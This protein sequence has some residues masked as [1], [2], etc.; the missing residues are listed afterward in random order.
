M[1]Q[2][3]QL[4]SKGSS[5]GFGFR[6][7]V[8]TVT[9]TKLQTVMKNLAT[10]KALWPQYVQ[11]LEIVLSVNGVK[12]TLPKG[13]AVNP[14]LPVVA[15][16]LRI[17]KWYDSKN[18][19]FAFWVRLD[20]PV[21]AALP[22]PALFEP[23]VT[24]GFRRGTSQDVQTAFDLGQSF[25]TPMKLEVWAPIAP[26]KAAPAQAAKPK[27][28]TPK[29]SDP[30]GVILPKPSQKFLLDENGFPTDG[31]RRPDGSI[32]VTYTV[33]AFQS[34]QREV[35]RLR[36]GAGLYP[37]NS[38]PPAA[39]VAQEVASSPTNLAYVAA[40]G[41]GAYFLFGAG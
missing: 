16:N 7:F 41:I 11:A 20:V 28:I 19:T 36:S 27:P 32:P 21:G 40:A 24:D 1:A 29:P 3:L 25:N 30:V 13:N 12:A 26:P 33:E 9:D 2:F 10:N 5:V 22:T 17:A 31:T 23:R 39:Q 8:L 18:H 37:P 34:L 38:K 35:L 15:K 14:G 4:I 6:L